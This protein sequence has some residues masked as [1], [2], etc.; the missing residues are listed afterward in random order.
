M[1]KLI[2]THYDRENPTYKME[3]E[4]GDDN[5]PE[6]VIKTPLKSNGDFRSAECIDLL[7]KNDI[8]DIKEF[9][10]LESEVFGYD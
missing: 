1:K 6:V 8:I 4:G 7:Q 2:S 10:F 3:Y 5:D 9:L